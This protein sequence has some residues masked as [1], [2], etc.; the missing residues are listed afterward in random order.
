MNTEISAIEQVR[1]RVLP[2]GRMTRDDA[3]RY[4]GVASKTLSNMQLRGIGPRSLKIRGRVFYYRT[5]LDVFIRGGQ[6]A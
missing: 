6:A 3:A 5:D 1:V 2:D 4:I